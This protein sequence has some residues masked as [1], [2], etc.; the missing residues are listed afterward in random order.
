MTRY[1]GRTMVVLEPAEVITSRTPSAFS[2]DVV[3]KIREETKVDSKLYDMWRSR[4]YTA[5]MQS[6]G[7][8]VNKLMSGDPAEM[9]K[10]RDT[11]ARDSR[12]GTNLSKQLDY[13]RSGDPDY[14]DP[15]AVPRWARGQQALSS[16]GQVR[17]G[18]GWPTASLYFDVTLNSSLKSRKQ[19]FG[20]WELRDGLQFL[21]SGRVLPY[22]VIPIGFAAN[23]LLYAAILW[24][25]ICGR[26][27]RRR[28]IRNRRSLCSACG[29][30]IGESPVCTECGRALARRTGVAT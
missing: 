13:R 27:T 16:W 15:D 14:I 23:T 1:P 2:G 21:G 10:L 19:V 17:S 3:V 26:T 4:Q 30:P 20:G 18:F 22:R 8:N 5:R 28:L 12:N 29:Y 11:L 24:S 6:L 7:I 9:A 25:L